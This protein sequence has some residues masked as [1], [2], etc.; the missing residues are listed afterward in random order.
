MLNSTLELDEYFCVSTETSSDLESSSS[1][2]E[3]LI[4]EQTNLVLEEV[5]KEQ[6]PS[7]T[8]QED[9]GCIKNSTK[10]DFDWKL[11]CRKSQLNYDGQTVIDDN[12][13]SNSFYLPNYD[14]TDCFCENTNFIS[15]LICEQP[16]SDLKMFLDEPSFEVDPILDKSIPTDNF[17]IERNSSE[18][19]N[20]LSEEACISIKGDQSEITTTLNQSKNSQQ[21][22]VNHK[23]QDEIELQTNI[24]D[25]LLL[26]N[27]F[28]NF[29]N[30][31]NCNDKPS[32]T[33]EKLLKHGQNESKSNKDLPGETIK[34]ADDF[35]TIFPNIDHFFINQQEGISNVNHNNRERDFTD[36]LKNRDFTGT[37]NYNE[38]TFSHI[39]NVSFDL[40][41]PEKFVEQNEKVS[42]TK[43]EKVVKEKQAKK[44]KNQVKK[45]KKKK[46]KEKERQKQKETNFKTNIHQKKKADPKT[47]IVNT[48]TKKLFTKQ[49]A[50][51]KKQ[52]RRKT[53]K[54][55]KIVKP[56]EKMQNL[57][58]LRHKIKIQN[59][60]KKRQKSKTNP[61]VCPINSFILSDEE[62]EEWNKDEDGEEWDE[63]E[64][65]FQ[66]NAVNRKRQKSFVA[67][68]SP[69]AKMRKT[70]NANKKS[71]KSYK[72]YADEVD[73]DRR[74]WQFV[75]GPK[76]RLTILKKQRKSRSERV[77]TSED[78]KSLFETW[79]LDHINDESGPYP[80]KE[81]RKWMTEKT[82][83]P[84][85][86]IQRWFGQ[87]RRLQIMHWK[88]GQAD[89]PNWI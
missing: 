55:K 17:M 60:S 64:K 88:N 89:K 3:N 6:Q 84:H 86:Q 53:K 16:D 22:K 29:E 77:L 71:K 19:A 68:S 43:K 72:I 11:N 13:L 56:T 81:T 80:N 50:K 74:T 46:E 21:L 51:P 33:K 14:N 18:Q 31:I 10:T 85:L 1:D 36:N 54:I 67:K 65:S 61:K 76:K 32:T 82:G 27:N 58:Y 42:Q 70:N 75:F 63:L 8:P 5:K 26:P 59:E 38:L 49:K 34:D 37:N 2:K 83:I 87:R 4:N 39:D 44:E 62:W 40:N 79:F 78:A 12:S 47:S 23:Y 73:W 69:N 48:K 35:S 52:A 45:K 66:N 30:I 7:Q 57:K 41:Y 24:N 20:W 28:D 9:L 25:L 15:W